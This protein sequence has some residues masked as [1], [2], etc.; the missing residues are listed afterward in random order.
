MAQ[1]TTTTK[2]NPGQLSHDLGRKPV[3]VTGPHDDGT[4]RIVADV[5][6]AALN[7]AVAAHTAQDGW[8]DPQPIADPRPPSL[9]EQIND[10]KGRL[11]RAANAAVT[12]E[13][14]KLRD[15]LKPTQ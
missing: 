8:T 6:D 1:M 11:D 10:L 9:Q 7:T 13:A 5:T 12:G 3:D 14:A 4:Y 2:I 15:N